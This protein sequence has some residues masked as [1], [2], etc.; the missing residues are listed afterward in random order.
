[1]MKIGI[2][3]F[4]NC[5]NY[6]ALLQAYSL[7][8]YIRNQGYEV[9]FLEHELN[10]E[11]PM[12]RKQG[13]LAWLK[14]K[15][16]DILIKTEKERRNKSFSLFVEH[17]FPKEKYNSS[18]DKIIIG[19]DQVW[20]MNLTHNDLYY[21]GTE[22]NCEIS[23]YA[24]SCGKFSSMSTDQKHL[25]V[26]NLQ[27]FRNISVRE[28]QT[29]KWLQTE[30]KQVV[31]SVLDP[32]LLVENSVFSQIEQQVNIK[33]K[34]VLVYDCMDKATYLFAKNI[35]Q[36]LNAKVIALSCCVR[37]RTHCKSFQA[38]S[39]EEFLWLFS[40]AECVVTTSFHGCAISLSYNKDFYAIN[41]NEETTSRIKELLESVGLMSRY[42]KVT[43][44][45]IVYESIEYTQVNGK[46]SVLREK[47]VSYLNKVLKS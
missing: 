44:S 37:A 17:N 24:A 3:T 38:A 21:L 39:V 27:K 19:S 46:L 31:S 34:F 8:F 18:F 15:L 2:L 23:S 35:A 5:D 25:I 42:V 26:D 32:T 41:F 43:D 11:V 28:Q 7:A 36:Q 1:M 20:N 4:Y 45:D 13:L 33:G 29:A 40:H 9:R 47:S 10:R 14:S 22:F 16:V 30:L 6:G 12:R